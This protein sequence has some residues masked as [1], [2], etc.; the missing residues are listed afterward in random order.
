M[1]YAARLAA[2]STDIDDTLAALDQLDA[3]SVEHAEFLATY[4]DQASAV[5]V[6]V[7]FVLHYCLA[8][9]HNQDSVCSPIDWLQ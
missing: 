8:Y 7:S 5:H 9:Q 1:Q 3:D 4:H 6:S 2:L